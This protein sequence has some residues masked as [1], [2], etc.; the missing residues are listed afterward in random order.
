MRKTFQYRLYPIRIQQ[1]AMQKALDAC[2]WVYNKTLETRRDAWRERKESMMLYDTSKLLPNWKQE[3]PFLN[4]AHSQSL[5]DAGARV[6]LAFKAFFRRVKAGENPGYPRFHGR[7]RYNSF[8]YPQSGFKFLNNK[9]LYLSKI[10]NIKIVLHRPIEGTIKTL[11]VRKNKLGNWHACFSCVVEPKPLSPSSKV[12]GIDMGLTHLIT[13]STGKQIENPRFFRKDEK[14]LAKAQRKFSQCKN[15]KRKRVVQHIHQRIANRRRDFAHKLSRQ[16]VNEFQILAFEN[17]DILQIRDNSW[18]SM[19]KSISDAAWNQL[20][21]Y[22]QYKAE[23]AGRECVL[24]D[25]RNTTQMCS[26]CGEIVPKDLSVRVHDCPHCSLILN[27]DHNAALN[28]LAL[29]LHGMGSIPRSR[30]TLLTRNGHVHVVRVID[31][32]RAA[33]IAEKVTAPSTEP[34][35]E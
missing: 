11:T 9:Q 25:P 34:S 20:I 10:G 1:T 8:T 7:N 33:K 32:E 12:V 13:L 22:T 3:N 18:R 21:R 24:V 26:G 5:Q 27:R 28:I 15:S 14:G 4:D 6:D 23:C 17:L 35:T 19:N 30:S 16:L 31:P 29:G 2:R